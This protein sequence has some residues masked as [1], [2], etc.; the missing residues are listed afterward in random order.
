M[1]SQFQFVKLKKCRLGECKGAN[2]FNKYAEYKGNKL[3]IIN[4]IKDFL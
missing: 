3:Y 2:T 1:K 4:L